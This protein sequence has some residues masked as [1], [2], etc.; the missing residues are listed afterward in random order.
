MV[1]KLIHQVEH[2]ETFFNGAW[3]WDFIF[4]YQQL[5]I[6]ITKAFAECGRIDSA[7]IVTWGIDFA[8]FN[9]EGY[10]MAN[11]LSYRND[12]GK[13]ALEN[14]NEEQKRFNF[15][16]S[17]IQCD[18]INTLYQILGFR[19]SYPEF[20][21]QAKKLLL[22][23][24]ILYYL[25]TGEMYAESTE[26]STSQCYDVRERAYSEHILSAYAIDKELFPPFIGHGSERGFLKKEIAEELGV[27][28]FP[29]ITIPSHD[30]AAAVAAV[31]PLEQ[32][33]ESLFISSGTWSLIGVELQAPLVNDAV[34]AS[35]FTNESGV[36]G[37]TTFLKNS[38]GLFIANRLYDECFGTESGVSWDTVTQKAAAVP[39]GQFLFDPNDE[40]FFNPR[41]MKETIIRK[42]GIK[43]QDDFV[44]FRIVY[45]SLAQSYKEGFEAIERLRGKIY[46]TVH[47]VGGGSKNRLLNE[48]TEGLTKKK[49]LAG[50]V[51][52][53]SLGNLGTQLL[54]K[55][56]AKD[57]AEV[58]RI[59]NR[60]W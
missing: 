20:F 10:F 57:L 21:A 11:P 13:T 15:F 36:L 56:R 23:P 50:P 9:R 35:G 28:V 5:K 41:S 47:I 54:Y 45:D 16:N 46:D 2:K 19:T 22:I 18:K 58:R 38:A 43:T 26:T 40:D 17:G 3:Y 7:A 39:N 29:F 42:T 44:L 8:L 1:T 31:L 60:V 48:L 24:D 49:V 52:A 51:E 53:A 32:E 59:I 6:G 12:F 33:E 27:N 55:G 14:L 37:T 4:I 34:Y 25:F 30:T